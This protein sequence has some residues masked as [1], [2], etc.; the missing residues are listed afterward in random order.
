MEFFRFTSQGIVVSFIPNSFPV[1]EKMNMK[2]VV[3]YFQEMYGY[4]II[5]SHLPCL[6]VGSQKKVNYLPLEVS[7]LFNLLNLF[8]SLYIMFQ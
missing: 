4:T 6:Q 2:S 8:S 1:D 5:Y 3:D 7:S